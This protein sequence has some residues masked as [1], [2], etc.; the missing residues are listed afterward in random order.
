MGCGKERVDQ[1][2]KVPPRASS[3]GIQDPRR[4]IPTTSP[5]PLRNVD[6]VTKIPRP[7]GSRLVIGQYGQFVQDYGCYGDAQQS[8]RSVPDN[9]DG[10]ADL[11]ATIARDLGRRNSLRSFNSQHEWNIQLSA[12]FAQRLAHGD[13]VVQKDLQD[14]DVLVQAAREVRVAAAQLALGLRAV[15]VDTGSPSTLAS[16]QDTRTAPCRP[17]SW[18]WAYN[19]TSNEHEPPRTAL[20]N[21]IGQDPGSLMP[22]G[23][24]VGTRGIGISLHPEHIVLRS[25][26]MTFQKRP[27]QSL[28]ARNV[29]ALRRPARTW[30]FDDS[31]EEVDV[32][33]VLRVSPSRELRVLV[34][35][36][37]QELRVRVGVHV[38]GVQCETHRVESVRDEE[39]LQRAD[40]GGLGAPTGPG[41]CRSSPYCLMTRP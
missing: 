21:G 39:V 17:C 27:P 23:L 11:F 14:R 5:K 37:V 8:E 6:E 9:W 31:G 41:S 19:S 18:Y 22:V 1:Q 12:Q 25:T 20:E 15:D 7:T 40:G 29:T 30:R 24:L 16:D 32:V 13:L 3:G 34:R 36:D 28:S 26:P 2:G 38:T 33:D 4:E 10:A 35:V